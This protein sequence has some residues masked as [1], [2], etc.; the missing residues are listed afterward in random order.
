LKDAIQPISASATENARPLPPSHFLSFT[1][2]LLITEF[3]VDSTNA[4]E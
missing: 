3:A 2:P 4:V 1:I